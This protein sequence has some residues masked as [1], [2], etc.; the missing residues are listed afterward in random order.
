MPESNLASL[1]PSRPE[2]I[3]AFAGAVGVNTGKVYQK[4]EALLREVGYECHLIH[5]IGLI[6]ELPLFKGLP[7]TPED[8]RIRE[9]MTAGNTFRQK[10]SRGDALAVMA[11]GAIRE[12]RLSLTKDSNIPKEGV[13]Y[14]IRS[15][16]NPEEVKTFRR[17]YGP[18][19]ILISVYSARSTRL[20]R[21][22]QII[23]TSQNDSAHP[24]AYRDRAETLIKSDFNEQGVQYGQNL[25]D[26]FPLADVFIEIS[27]NEPRLES[28]L[29]KFV[30]LLFRHPYHTPNRDEYGMFMAFSGALRSSDLGRQVGAA[31]SDDHG[32]ILSVGTNEVP[33]PGGGQYWDEDIP[34]GRDFNREDLSQSHS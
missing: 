31:I 19:F 15:L 1:P 33:R 32:D 28:T 27:D 16:K 34:N 10:M 2:L 13:A 9:R 11:M 7:T 20:E 6:E 17:V 22:S 5:V 14:I 29:C 12:K 26:A 3:I 4:L 21:L 23:A 30:Q 24:D 8:T 18:A 25:R